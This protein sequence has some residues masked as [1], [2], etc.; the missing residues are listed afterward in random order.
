ME[1]HEPIWFGKE[2]RP[3]EPSD[4]KGL[5]P[6]SIMVATPVHSDV[7]IHYTQSLLELQK[8]CI[9]NHVWLEF[10]IMK[11]SLVTQ[12]RNMCVSAF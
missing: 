4:I 10:N 6:Y 5:K 3:T 1:N 12:G 8:W 2:T 7:S 9:K 11:S